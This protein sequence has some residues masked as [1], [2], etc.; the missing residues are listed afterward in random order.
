MLTQRPRVFP[1]LMKCV[2]LGICVCDAH[3]I[4]V[5]SFKELCVFNPNC[6][7][8][9]CKNQPFHCK[10]YESKLLPISPMVKLFTK[11]LIKCHLVRLL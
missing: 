5:G 2:M 4:T 1:I 8:F 6:I 11:T 9:N 10:I 3:G 7:A